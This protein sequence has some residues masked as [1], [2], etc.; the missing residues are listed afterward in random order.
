MTDILHLAQHVE[1]WHWAL[2]AGLAVIV[3]ALVS[4][5]DD[6]EKGQDDEHQ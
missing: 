6:W 4:A 3:A 5:A 1:W 2:L